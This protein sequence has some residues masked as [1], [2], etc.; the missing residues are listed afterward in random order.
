M[1]KQSGFWSVEERLE[2][3]SAGGDPLE[4]LD[5]AVEFERFRSIL[6]RASGRPRGSKGGRPEMDRAINQAGF[7]RAPARLW[8]PA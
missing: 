1:A 2:E 5:R 3:I 4:T 6:E 7:I 8:T